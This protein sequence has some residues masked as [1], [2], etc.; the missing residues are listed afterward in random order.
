MLKSFFTLFFIGLVSSLS[1]QNPDEILLKDY[2][3]VSIYHTPKAN[4]QKASF[5]VIDMHSHNYVP[6]KDLDDL[7]K[8]MDKMNI[9]K[10]I[11]LSM[12][13]GKGFDSVVE[14]YS[15]YPSRF[16]VWCG[17]DYTGYGTAGWQK[18]AVAELERCYKKGARGVGELGDKGSGEL[19]SKP[20]PGKGLHIDD[21][22]MKPLLQKCAE[23][24]LP[25]SIHVAEDAW[26]YEK[27]DSTNDGL[28]NSATWHVN[29][30]EP[31][32]LGHD[33]LIK[34]LVNA[35]RENP[36]VTFIACHLMNLCSNLQVLGKIL[37]K[38]PN[39]YADIG[40][41]F[42]E[43][44]PVPRYAAAFITKYQDRIVYGTDNYPGELMYQTTFRIL[45]T[46]DEH[47]YERSLFNY[48]WP[49][50]G[51]DLPQNVLEKLYSKN[52]E[53]ILEHK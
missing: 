4:I 30:N 14:K 26:M 35:V 19:Y 49:L 50:Y 42:A 52:A 11:I 33:E 17:F 20:T 6:E 41:R 39:L 9:Q 48:H 43:I 36:K 13:T 47:F 27:P 5:P 10:V 12:Q 1:A 44:A 8:L 45:E 38:Y 51:L 24:H 32:K 25:I 23:L 46:A 29:M 3:P 34:S 53:K 37:D 7:V 21:P 2:K 40:A 31:A 18:H 22:Q 15:R 28:M 16:E